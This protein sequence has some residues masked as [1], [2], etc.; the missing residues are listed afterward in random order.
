MPIGLSPLSALE[1]PVWPI[2][3]SLHTLPFP[4]CANRAPGMSLFHRSVSGPHR[5]G[6]PLARCVQADTPYQRWEN[7]TQQLLLDPGISSSPTGAHNNLQFAFPALSPPCGE[8]M[9]P[10]PTCRL[11]CRCGMPIPTRRTCATR[12]DGWAPEYAICLVGGGHRCVCYFGGGQNP[13]VRSY[14]TC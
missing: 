6:Q 1:I 12:G 10:A 8:L 13:N 4:G 5:G 7:P 9:F 14:H 11:S 3:T 2:P